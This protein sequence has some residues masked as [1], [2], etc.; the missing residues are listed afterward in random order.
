M[1]SLIEI[2]FPNFFVA[3]HAVSVSIML[4]VVLIEQ[5]S[6]LSHL[7]IWSIFIGNQWGGDSVLNCTLNKSLIIK[8]SINVR[9]KLLVFRAGFP[10]INLLLNLLLP[11]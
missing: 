10:L 1:V 7:S 11:L 5:V 8:L 3:S 6:G 4:G 2:I 9:E